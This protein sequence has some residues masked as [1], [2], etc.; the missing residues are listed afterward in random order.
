MLIYC[1][2]NIYFYDQCWKHLDCLDAFCFFSILWWIEVQKN[3]IYFCILKSL[4]ESVGR[5]RRSVEL[6]RDLEAPPEG[7]HLLSVFVSCCT[8]SQDGSRGS[9]ELV[10]VSNFEL[11][12]QEAL[13]DQSIHSRWKQA[14]EWWWSA[15]VFVI[16]L[17]LTITTLSGMTQAFKS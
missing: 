10:F 7:C 2:R 4:V 8:F 17:R 14:L 13:G 15:G 9:W 6:K 3:S 12:E 5:D 16:S 11:D 1:S